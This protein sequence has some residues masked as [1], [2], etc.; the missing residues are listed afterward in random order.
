MD[1]MDWILIVELKNGGEIY[2]YIHA[3]IYTCIY[4]HVYVY[5]CIYIVVVCDLVRYLALFD[6]LVIREM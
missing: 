4:I 6:R 1:E 2:I 3:Y 5:V